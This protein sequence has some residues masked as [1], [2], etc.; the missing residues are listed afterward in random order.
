MFCKNCGKEVNLNDKFCA[1]CGTP[2]EQQVQ[3]LKPTNTAAST[4]EKGPFKV[5]AIIG[6]VMGF[7]SII[8]GFVPYLCIFPLSGLAASIVGVFSK[9]RRGKAIAGIVLNSIGC[10]ISAVMIYLYIYY[11]LNPGES[12]GLFS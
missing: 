12:G 6:F 10:I 4:S 7:I 5:F 3:E 11:A 2:L 8:L 1:F 9:S